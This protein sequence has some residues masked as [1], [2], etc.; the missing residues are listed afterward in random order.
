MDRTF[1]ALYAEKTLLMIIFISRYNN[2]F[3]FKKNDFI[4]HAW[5]IQCFILF[6]FIFVNEWMNQ[7]RVGEKKANLLWKS[8]HPTK[9]YNIK[10]YFH[11]QNKD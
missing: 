8:H 9:V 1:L 2:I 4:C 11:M 6:Q 5:K 10:V 7:Q 3:K